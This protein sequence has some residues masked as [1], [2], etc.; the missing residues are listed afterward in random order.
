MVVLDF[1]MRMVVLDF[2]IRMVVLDFAMR[3]VVLDFAIRMVVLDFAMCL[4]ATFNLHMHYCFVLCHH[5]HAHAHASF[6]STTTKPLP[7][8]NFVPSESHIRKRILQA[9]FLSV[10]LTKFACGLVCSCQDVSFHPSHPCCLSQLLKRSV[11]RKWRSLSLAQQRKW[12]QG[13]IKD[14][15][16]GSERDRLVAVVKPAP[17]IRLRLG[18]IISASVHLR[19]RPVKMLL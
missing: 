1:A 14:G 2:A 4:H 16:T 7:D 12:A 18:A 13:F 10:L 5:A 3:M 19:Q 15:I 8:I 17:P 6:I 9:S 11:I